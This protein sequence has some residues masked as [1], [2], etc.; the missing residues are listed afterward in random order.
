[1]YQPV[2]LY[3]NI[4]KSPKAGNVGNDARYNHSLFQV[5]DFFQVLVELKHTD[6]FPRVA[7]GFCQFVNNI[8]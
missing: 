4:D 5:V 8:G 7:P 1:M 2:F 6:F 3:A